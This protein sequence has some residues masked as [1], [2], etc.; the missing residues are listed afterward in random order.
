MASLGSLNDTTV[1]N[2]ARVVCAINLQRLA[3]ILND[4]ITCAFSLAND[5]SMHYGM[6]YF[7]NRICFHR[8]GIPYNVHVLTIPMFEQHTSENMSNLVARFLDIVC[9]DWCAKLIGVSTDGASAMTGPVKGVATR[10]KKE[11]KYKIYRIWCGLHQLDLVLKYAYEALQCPDG[12]FNKIMHSFT[13]KLCRQQK[14]INDMLDSNG[15]Y[16]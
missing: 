5:A 4:D 6:S 9:S 13:G 14:L 3:N 15:G 1:V 10:I 12:E 2:Y 11:A 8:D 16:M 7:D